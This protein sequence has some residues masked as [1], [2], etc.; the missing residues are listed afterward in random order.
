MSG[1]WG[2]G[3]NKSLCVMEPRLQLKGFPLPAGLEPGTARSAGQ[4]LT[5]LAKRVHHTR[6][7][8]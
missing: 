8:A 4:P 5:Y 3:E 1:Q 7:E 2:R 6:N